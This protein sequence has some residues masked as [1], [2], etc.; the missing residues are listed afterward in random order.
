MPVTVLN[1]SG[2]KGLAARTA[3]SLRRGG[4]RVVAVGNSHGSVPASTVYFPAGAQDQATALAA[5]LPGA[6]RVRP[7]AASMSRGS[8]TVVL[9]SSYPG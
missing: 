7:A 5:L 6:D 9:T 1:Q 3:A 2:R 8:L 4:W